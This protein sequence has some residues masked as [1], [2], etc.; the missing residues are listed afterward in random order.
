[1]SGYG[2]GDRAIEVRSPTGA[3]DF[4]FSLC[5]PTGSGA[6]PAFCLVGTG[7][8]FPGVKR[9]RGVTLTTHFHL[10]PPWCVAE[11]LYF[12]LYILLQVALHKFALLEAKLV[13]NVIINNKLQFLVT[14]VIAYFDGVW[15]DVELNHLLLETSQ[16]SGQK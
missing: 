15:N 9:G 14:S 3:K 10:V 4:S 11:L 12:T 8:P 16:V 7:G 13:R 2:L 1:M 5:V 6:H